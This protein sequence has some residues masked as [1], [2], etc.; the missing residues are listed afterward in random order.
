MYHSFLKSKKRV[1]I[2]D[3]SFKHDFKIPTEI[4]QSFLKDH[5]NPLQ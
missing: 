3:S 5:S 1:I 4:I 2:E